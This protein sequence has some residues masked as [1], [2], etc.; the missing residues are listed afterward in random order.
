MEKGSWFNNISRFFVPPDQGEHPLVR[1][2]KI[3]ADGLIQNSAHR[4]SN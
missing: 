2:S 4:P 1:M 3:G